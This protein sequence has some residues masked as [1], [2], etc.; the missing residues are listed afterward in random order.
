MFTC[1]DYVVPDILVLGKGLGG[2]VMPLAAI[3][4]RLAA[5][6]ARL[7]DRGDGK[8]TRGS[9]VASSPQPKHAEV[10]QEVRAGRW[11]RSARGCDDELLPRSE[12]KLSGLSFRSFS[13]RKRPRSPERCVFSA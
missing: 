2:G 13:S 5:L 10:E 3:V 1:E 7:S 9:R 11:L 8:A 6:A 4:A 12:G